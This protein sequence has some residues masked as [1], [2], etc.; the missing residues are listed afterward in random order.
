MG[1]TITLTADRAN[2]VLPVEFQRPDTG[3]WVDGVLV[4]GTTNTYRA[5]F[6][7]IPA[8]TY[9]NILKARLK[10]SNPE[11]SYVFGQT[12]IVVDGGG[13]GVPPSTLA[14]TSLDPSSAKVG[15]TIIINGSGFTGALNVLFA[16]VGAGSGKYSVLSDSQITAVVPNVSAGSNPVQVVGASSTSSARA[17]IVQAAAVNQLP[18]ANAG[19]D[20]NIQLPTSSLVLQGTASDADAGDTLTYVWRQITGPSNATGMP[21][22]SLNVVVSNLVMG[23]YQF[24][25]QSTDQKGGKS[26]EDLVVVTVAAAATTGSFAPHLLSGQ[27]LCLGTATLA[28]IYQS[29]INNQITPAMDD[30]FQR[31]YIWS[32]TANTVV[33]LG[34]NTNQSVSSLPQYAG[35][36]ASF[37]DET[38]FAQLYENNRTGDNYQIKISGDGQS[39]DNWQSKT[40][41][42]L[43]EII[44]AFKGMK[45]WG[46]TNSLAVLP[47]ATFRWV[48]GQADGGMD[49]SVYLN[50]FNFI[51]T[52]LIEE[53]V[54]DTNT[55][56]I[57][58]APRDG[59][60]RTAQQQFATQNSSFAS[61]VEIGDLS[62]GTAN[63]VNSYDGTH[64]TAQGH[65]LMSERNF[66]AI[67]GGNAKIYTAVVAPPPTV[68]KFVRLS[69]GGGFGG[70]T[71]VNPTDDYEFEFAAAMPDAV[72]DS[73]TTA[74]MYALNDGQ[75]DS[76]AILYGFSGAG[77]EFFS[78]R[79]SP[80]IRV[81]WPKPTTSAR[82]IYKAKYTNGRLYLYLNG[83]LLD[84]AGTAQPAIPVSATHGSVLALRDKSNPFLGD[85]DYIK[86]TVA[87]VPKFFLEFNGD[88]SDS[89]GTTNGLSMEGS[90]SYITV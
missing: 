47:C 82:T 53:G 67:Y 59:N 25:F 71:A 15:D 60:A 28:D 32:T 55:K 49:V 43:Y 54:I 22:T 38:G 51:R 70:T 30:E 61:F 36:P 64:L 78:Q 21:A 69:G 1:N 62:N 72:R 20:V 86:I 42:R 19:Q 39:I 13:G 58:D 34:P 83:T 66:A 77:F 57:L 6:T 5:V 3:A 74:Y 68:Q 63:S 45:A 4:S 65:I 2:T 33:K 23:T 44:Q 50:K 9:T 16:G 14:I 29:P 90:Y 31:S 26:T 41:G 73:V 89:T 46:V 88:A 10:G 35:R 12:V 40:N 37:G 80:Y 17:F 11:V 76:I 27:S 56:F 84:A 87:G 52:S 18:V 81:A 75:Q 85:V 8:G 79:T 48:Q 24:G 7:G